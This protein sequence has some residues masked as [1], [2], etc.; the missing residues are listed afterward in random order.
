[1]VR[2]K[3]IPKKGKSKFKGQRG[4]TPLPHRLVPG[5][6]SKP[7]PIVGLGASAGG[8]EALE[9]FIAQVPAESGIAFIVVTHQ[10]PGH[11]SMLPELLQKHTRMRVEPAV[12]GA[13]V[14]PNHTYLSS[15][16]GYLAILNGALHVME[17]EDPGSLRLPIDYFFRSLAD[18]QKEKAIGIVLSGTGT[19]GTLGL[20]AIKGAAGMTMAQEPESAKY[21]GMP[22]S[23]IATGLV[24][25]ILPVDQMPGRLLAYAKGPYVALVEPDGADE[26]ELPEPMQKIN[27][28][29]RLRTGHD[30]SAYK[31]NTIR[32]RIERRINIH[33]LKGPQQYLQL[34]H[35]NPNELD[36]MF[37]ELLIG[38]TH[39]FRDPEA[40]DTLAKTILPELLASRPDSSAVRVWVAGCS[41]GEEAYSLAILFQ[42]AMDR[43][44]KHFTV[45]IFGTDLD[46]H[47]IH[48]ARGGYYPEGIA[49]DVT[50]KRLARF[51][52]KEENGYRVKK[53]IREMVIF[54]TQNVLK[55]PPFTKLDVVAC[56]NLLIYFKP[57]AQRRLL[58]LFHYALKPHGILFLGTSESIS[59]FGDHFAV[60]NKKW[61]IF[62][63]KG[64]IDKPALQQEFSPAV[65]NTEPHPKA[66]RD[67]VEETRKLHLPVVIEKMLL[68]CFVPASVIVNDRGDIIYIHGR[69]GDFLEAAAGQPRLNI[70]EM[71]RE[72]LRVELSTA[73][74]R[75]VSQDREVVQG[76]IRVKTNGD[77]TSVRLTVRKLAE[78]ETI[79]GLI[80]VMFQA[81]PELKPLPV[82]KAARG[83]AP[84]TSDLVPALERELQYTKETLQSTVEELETSNEELK[85]TNEEMQS[86]NE[87]L[88]S[89]NEELETSKE[90]M[91]SL[92]EELQTVNA[93]LQA[94]VDDLG[95]ANDDMQNLLNSMEIAT[96][97]LDEN[98]KVKRF[99]V[100]AT[101]LVN[102]IPSDVGRP[103][104]DLASNLDYDRLQTDAAEVLRRLVPK[105]RQVRTRKGDWREVRISPYRTTENVIDGLVVTFVDIN[106]V[107]QAE[108]AAR[109]G[110]AYA[111]S[112]VATVREPMVVLDKN[113]RVVSI[114]EAFC[115]VFGL[116]Q[117]KVE[118]H[119]IYT[120]NHGQ[121][122]IP[123]LRKLLEN[124]LP[125]NIVFNDFKVTHRFL[126]V[127]PKVLLLNAR[128]LVRESGLPAMIL[129]AIEDV[130]AQSGN[131]RNLPIAGKKSSRS[132]RPA[133]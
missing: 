112:I 133:R 8:L 123:Q 111:E 15:S 57:E 88:Q 63:S 85:S 42:E 6:P 120:L 54:A 93:Q 53:E 80:L 10:H 97:F 115:R 110:R 21:A 14:E 129:L 46:S 4:A 58:E 69:T 47:A 7:F 81:E 26:A 59:S 86:T 71:A 48:I 92:N 44:K 79:R 74:R 116:S 36:L 13:T 128:R 33:Q 62:T 40:F 41:T 19:D 61:K 113:L 108:E 3:P 35:D 89:V 22:N 37:R 117:K 82:R 68:K 107:K 73:L 12:D 2:N 5:R 25:Y 11:V 96:I 51:F 101:K 64:A 109:L 106:A 65:S 121:W 119:L 77:F 50:S 114:N 60:A 55:D 9:K 72:G 91:Q 95:Q 122:D 28:L 78:P 34:L 98:F 118:G 94:K 1:M 18:D 83:A 29:L 99:T 27:V 20:K 75:A 43:V 32:R 125:K 127:G 70:L 90:E 66:E 76:G 131:P 104:A 132:R 56:R 102:L 38:V 67:G 30:F 45:Q 39:F 100:E 103:L 52:I 130:T 124:I 84:P 17:P 23:A 126:G 31:P 16:E 87:E 24:D 105:R 49:R